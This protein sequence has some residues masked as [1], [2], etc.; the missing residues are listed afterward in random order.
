MSKT[1]RSTNIR[2]ARPTPARKFAD[3]DANLA[4]AEERQGLDQLKHERGRTL[5]AR[6]LFRFLQSAASERQPFLTRKVS[7]QPPHSLPMPGKFAFSESRSLILALASL[8]T[9]AKLAIRASKPALSSQI[10]GEAL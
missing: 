7:W 10:L 8:T 5:Q 2:T 6:A 1:G 3:D 4:P 9:L